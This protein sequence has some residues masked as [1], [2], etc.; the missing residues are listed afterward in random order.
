MAGYVLPMRTGGRCGETRDEADRRHDRSPAQE[1]IM[2]ALDPQSDATNLT[3][4]P[5][6]FQNQTR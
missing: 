1:V 3:H 5:E 4:A 6:Q 2:R